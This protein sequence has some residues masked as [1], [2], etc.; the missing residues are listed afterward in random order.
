MLIG[1]GKRMQGPMGE[2]YKKLDSVENVIRHLA[3]GFEKVPGDNGVNSYESWLEKGV[4][5]KKPYIYRQINGDFFEWDGVDYRKPMSEAD[6]KAKL[7]KT[8]SGKFEFKSDYL[9]HYADYISEKFGISKEKVPFPQWVEPKYSG[10]GDLFFVT[11]KTS[12]HGEGRTA[13][14][15]QVISIY[16]PVSGGRNEMF[17]EMHPS[18]AANA[19][20][21]NGDRVKISSNARFDHIARSH[22]AGRTPGYCRAAVRIRPLGAGTLGQGT[23]R[24]HL[25]HHPERVRSDLRFDIELFRQ[26]HHRKGV[27]PS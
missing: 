7:L 26:S 17:L 1:V 5:Y 20:I 11:P 4:W 24:Q 15:P 9:D 18:A 6:V 12:V 3:K 19:G 16:Q 10:T 14:I 8:P 23:R 2:Y 27:S 13:N 25:R 21:K 22:H